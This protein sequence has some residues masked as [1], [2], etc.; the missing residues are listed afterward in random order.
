MLAESPRLRLPPIV[1]DVKLDLT[2]AGLTNKRE[3]ISP[4]P[5]RHGR[6]SAAAAARAP[7]A[8]AARAVAAAVTGPGG[9]GDMAA[10][11]GGP[12]V[13]RPPGSRE[14]LALALSGVRAVV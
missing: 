6:P 14:E 12:P 5:G 9:V 2:Y 3:G 10:D 8:R 4:L 13:R 7:P 1:P 11:G